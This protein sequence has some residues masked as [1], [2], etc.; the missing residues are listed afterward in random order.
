MFKKTRFMAILLIFILHIS[1]ITVNAESFENIADLGLTSKSAVLMEANS[2]TI[3]Y[4]MNSH[5]KL[6]P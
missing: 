6:H 1:L 3:L 2:G 5:E 4:E